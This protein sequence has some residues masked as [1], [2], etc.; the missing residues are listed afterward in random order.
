MEQNKTYDK[1]HKHISNIIL[2]VKYN[3]IIFS[4]YNKFLYDI[5]ETSD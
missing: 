1:K 4:H 5:R 3:I 2:Y